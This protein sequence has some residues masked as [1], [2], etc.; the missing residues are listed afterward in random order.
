MLDIDLQIDPQRDE[1]GGPK[2]EEAKEGDR[3][4]E[5]HVE[6]YAADQERNVWRQ[7]GEEAE[8][9][10]AN[11]GQQ[12]PR[13]ARSRLV[14]RLNNHLRREF[15]EPSAG[16]GPLHSHNLCCCY[17]EGNI[18]AAPSATRYPSGWLFVF[19]LRRPEHRAR[20]L[21]ARRPSCLVPGSLSALC[22]AFLGV[23]PAWGSSSSD[24]S[25]GSQHLGRLPLDPV[26]VRCILAEN[27]SDPKNH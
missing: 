17:A 24:D 18:L 5:R 6:R 9:D 7:E 4:G 3:S 1:D 23:L 27:F 14:L 26:L 13:N 21:G 8:R 11:K 12:D 22:G 16:S 25:E 15:A 20:S 10:S 19:R 2:Q